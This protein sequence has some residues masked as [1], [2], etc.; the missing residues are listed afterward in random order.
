MY[1]NDNQSGVYRGSLLDFSDPEI[2]FAFTGETKGTDIVGR[3]YYNTSEGF[4]ETELPGVSRRGNIFKS[5]LFRI[6][7]RGKVAYLAE[8][9]RKAR[10]Y[11]IEM[12]PDGEIA[13]VEVETEEG[14]KLA[15][16]KEYDLPPRS[17]DFVEKTYAATK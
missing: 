6:S 4:S 8:K 14:W 7:W 2:R 12:S 3:T 15:P 11:K 16:Q 1:S 17:Q 9:G 5:V 10:R 13:K